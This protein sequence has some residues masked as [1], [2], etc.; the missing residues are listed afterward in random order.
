[1]NKTCSANQELSYIENVL[2]TQLLLTTTLFHFGT[3]NWEEKSEEQP[4]SRHQGN[5]GQTKVDED[6]DTVDYQTTG[7]K[8]EMQKPENLENG[9]SLSGT[10]SWSNRHTY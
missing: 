5:Y 6:K 3:E 7:G 2:K 8:A 9:F 1:M 4:V 10:N